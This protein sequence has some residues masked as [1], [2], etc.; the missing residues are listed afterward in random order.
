MLNQG[1]KLAFGSDLPLY[2]FD[3]LKGIYAAVTRKRGA[4]DSSWNP[5]EKISVMQAVQAYT[6]GAAY[7]SYEENLKGSLEVGKLADLV[8]LSRDIF[9]IAPAEILKTV[10]LATIWDGKIVYNDDFV[11]L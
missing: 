4:K 10:V 11:E 5:K 7:A 1:I 9:K 2:N 8:V 3:P 6:K